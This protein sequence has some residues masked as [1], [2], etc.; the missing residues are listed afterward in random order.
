MPLLPISMNLMTNSR[1]INRL[2]KIITA[3]TSMICIML[4]QALRPFLGPADCKF[5]P[6]CTRYAIIQLQEQPLHKAFYTIAKRL[7]ACNPFF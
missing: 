5:E 1:L 6:S 7:L 3:I 2:H 4:I